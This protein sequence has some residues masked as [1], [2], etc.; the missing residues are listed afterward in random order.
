MWQVTTMSVAAQL[1][2][3]YFNMGFTANLLVG[4]WATGYTDPTSRP[5]WIQTSTVDEFFKVSRSNM[6][7]GRR[8][9]NTTIH[10]LQ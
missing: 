8:S 5:N 4:A 10:H 3:N 2:N 7:K 6:G 1:A 9:L